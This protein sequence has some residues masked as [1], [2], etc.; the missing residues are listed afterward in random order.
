M[1]EALADRGH[2]VVDLSPF[3]LK[4]PRAN[5]T[6]LDI[7]SEFPSLVNTLTYEQ[8]VNP[9][10]DKLGILKF[11]AAFHGESFCRKVFST[12]HFQV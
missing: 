4:T 5:Y 6:D 8:M 3:P 7:S 1:L 2:E 12:Q 10:V 11:I 9:D